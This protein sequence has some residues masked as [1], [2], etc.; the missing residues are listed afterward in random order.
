MKAKAAKKAGPGK[1]AEACPVLGMGFHSV[2]RS[3][4][5][6]TWPVVLGIN[7]FF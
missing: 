3:E 7:R 5:Q 2:G 1:D 6:E 4:S